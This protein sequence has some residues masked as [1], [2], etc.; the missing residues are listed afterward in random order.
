MHILISLL[1]AAEPQLPTLLQAAPAA[2][3]AGAPLDQSVTVRLALQISDSG[4]VLEVQVLEPVGQGFDEAAVL[5]ARATRFLPALDQQGDPAPATIEY[6]VRF[7]AE[8]LPPL[9]VEGQVM[10]AGGGGPLSGIEI[11]ALGPDGARA[12][13]TTDVQGFFQLAGL[14]GGDWTLAARSPTH[15]PETVDLV[16]REGV[17]SQATLYLVA[18]ERLQAL[19]FDQQI[20][21][22]GTRATSEVTERRLTSEEIRYLPG[23]NGDVVK[24]VQNLPGV[25]RP[26]LGTGNLI[27]RGT[28]PEQ[29]LTTLDGSPIPLV[30]HFAGLTAVVPSDALSEVAYVPGNASVRYGRTLGGVVDLRTTT[31]LPERDHGYVSVDLYQSAFFVERRLSDTTA[32]TVAGRRSYIDAVLGPV[33]SQGDLKVQAPRYYDGQLRLVHETPEATWDV[34]VYG[35]DDR[36]RF[37][38]AEED[39][40]FASYADRFARL[41]VR[42]LDSVGAWDRETSLAMGPES[43]FFEFSTASEAIESRRMLSFRQELTL[44]VSADRPLGFRAGIDLQAG[45]EE[46]LFYFAN[47]GPKEEGAAFKWAPAAYLESTLL[48]GDLTLIAGLR[49]DV[50]SWTGDTVSTV[51]QSIDPR[52]TARY[53]VADYTT[54]KGSVGRYSSFPTL[55]QLD[56]GADGNPKLGPSHS[57]QGSVGVE[58]QLFGQL[59]VDATAF[60][61]RLDR[62]VVGREDRLRFYTGP[63]PIGPFDTDPYA[64]DGIGLIYGTE[65]LLRYDSPT[66]VGLLSLTLSHSERQDRP[67]EP[68]E[69]FEYDQPLVLNALWSQKLPRNWRAGARLRYGSGN[70]YTPVVNSYLDL[71]SRRWQPVYGERSSARLDPFV[72]LDLRVDKTWTF[73]QWKLVGYLEVQNATFAKSP[74]VMSWNYDYSVEQP[75]TSNPPLPVFGVRG[76]W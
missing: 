52:L 59:R 33:L 9:S 22:E 72:S 20:V 49:G 32:I 69:L 75:F 24:V 56:P 62:L 54:V 21:V 34:L 66:S 50:V 37:L 61:N 73:E 14:T 68:V 65:L 36:F 1:L 7:D 60:V 26:P 11:E 44:P 10:E 30:F 25:A 40:V 76:E 12:F 3:P 18:D 31:S 53:A 6:R 38:G 55:R 47:V 46:F 63:P 42:R 48:V 28:S 4:E 74:E 15:G 8:A 57:L 17:V 13:A 5:A 39:E 29:S 71:T 2:W 58:Q 45:T 41:R 19:S 64:N 23:T 35:S 67:G 27:I 16:V 51:H 43:R 70:P